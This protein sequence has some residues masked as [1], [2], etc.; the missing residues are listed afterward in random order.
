MGCSLLIFKRIFFSAGLLIATVLSCHLFSLPA[1][2]IIIRHGEK[3]RKGEYLD[4][5]GLERSG[6]LVFFFQNDPTVLR[7]GLPVAIFA[8]NPVPHN[9]SHREIQTV[10]PL[11][12]QLG[13]QILT[14]FSR[15]EV[16]ELANLVL[17]DSRY[18]G[19][20]VLICWEHGIM[21]KLTEAFGVA[22]PVTP[23]PG[24]RFDLVYH[25]TFADPKKPTFCVTLQN[26]M[27]DDS[28]TPP[29]GFPRCES[30]K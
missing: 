27:Q 12:K 11:A 5:R 9:L 8:A 26:L 20:M 19:K 15:P 21:D 10:T 16:N 14:P 22:G 25:I 7:S 2:V 29:D 6:A 23:Y 13:L 18:D 3:P 24:T 17:K 4:L 1:E 28:H 30:I